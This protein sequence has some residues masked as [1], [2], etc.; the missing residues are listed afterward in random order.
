[1]KT[2]SISDS[3]KLYNI[4]NW[5]D[6]YFSINPS[7]NVTVHPRKGEGT[8]VD[9]K[10]VIEEIK[11]KGLEFP[12]LIRFQD[13]IRHRVVTL[14]E[15]FRK[16]IAEFGYKGRYQGVYPIKVNQMREVVEEIVDAGRPYDFG[17]EAGS[18]AE[19]AAV[20][21]MSTNP[22]ALTICNGY[23][24][25]AFIKTAL[26]GLKLGKQ[27]IIVVEK[28][29]EIHQIIS[30][31]KE[32]G[33]TPQIGIRVKLYSKGS[34]KWESSGGEFAKFGLTTPE[35]IHAVQVLQKEGMQDCFRLLHF[36][37]GS[38]ITHIKT[39]KNAVKEGTRIYAKLRKMGLS[40]LEFLDVG[41]GLGVDY[42][43]SRTSFE[44]SINYSL[45]E[46][47]SDIVYSIQEVCQAEEVPEPNIVSESGRALVA[48][49]SV[50]IVN[51][52]GTIE[53][54]ATPMALEET[55]DEADVVKEIRY[56]LQN[57]STKNLLEHFHDAMQRKE[58]ALSMFKLGF[59]SLEDKAKVEHL[60]WQICKVIHKNS[61]GL[62]YVP[63]EVEALKKHLADQYLCNFSLFQSMPDHW[64]IQHLF[65]IVPL[66]RH[67][68]EPT[69]H[70][71]LV[72]IT[73]D[74]DGKVSKFIDLRDIKDTLPLHAFRGTDPYYLGFFLMGAYQD[75]MGDLHNLF[76]RVNEVHVFL[77]ETE[78][79]GH[80][81]EE[82]IRGNTI[83]GVL[84]WIQYS[85]TDL[86]KKVKEQID[87][88][89]REGLIKP[90]EGVELQN[91]YQNVLYGY[92]YVDYEKQSKV[93]QN[94]SE[95]VIGTT[96]SVGS[97]GMTSVSGLV[98]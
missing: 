30:V 83:A 8:G 49:H 51:V 16:S 35:L 96:E 97:M 41:G 47:V 91:F 72:D 43:G 55:P 75:I 24:D 39:I 45:A 73:C 9:L 12:V 48:H 32:L 2:W 93:F 56:L 58:E 85:A 25:Y 69:H 33:V 38:Q 86:E 92:T 27:V 66:H 44:S 70:S 14:N 29:S 52:F 98:E 76:G 53:V 11:A 37:I 80:Y 67:D 88:K 22:N 28:L 54:G 17:L 6:Q 34:G 65:P 94:S 18:K 74:S 19:L 64:A 15:A 62:R 78:P 20:L 21:A 68:E 31:A 61:A 26:M 1:M 60:F 23:K 71:T 77:D 13:I 5:G 87:M 57:L 63:E 42:D 89:V 84:S 50:L 4:E 46:Y 82:V 36:H 95:S 7:G 59:L 3:L 81:I 10:N 79:G 40:S 90:K